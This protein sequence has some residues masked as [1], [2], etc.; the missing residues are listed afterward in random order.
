[1][2]ETIQKYLGLYLKSIGYEY[3]IFR[4]KKKPVPEGRG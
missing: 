2:I 4:M 1:M 3:G